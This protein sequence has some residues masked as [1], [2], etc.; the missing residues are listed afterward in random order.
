MTYHGNRNIANIREEAKNN[1]ISSSKV[2]ETCVRYI[3]PYFSN[4]VLSL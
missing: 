3:P 4:N 1:K 2:S